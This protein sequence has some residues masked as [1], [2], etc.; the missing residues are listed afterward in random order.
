MQASAG[1]RARLVAGAAQTS[2][3]HRLAYVADVLLLFC[4]R[5]NG[6]DSFRQLAAL[7]LRSAAPSV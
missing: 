2:L 5:A 4:L 6:N 7:L 3:L 1:A